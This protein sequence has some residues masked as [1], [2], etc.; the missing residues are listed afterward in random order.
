MYHQSS[1]PFC[2][3]DKKSKKIILKLIS[4][5]KLTSVKVLYG[6]PFMYHKT[7]KNDLHG[8]AVWEWDYAEM[9]LEKQYSGDKNVMWK[10]E[11]TPPKTK[12]L[13]YLFVIQDEKN[14]AFLYSENG[15]KEIKPGEIKI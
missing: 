14:N 15:I 7:A 3:Y 8:N 9:P 12:R 2:P 13:K 1:L 11:F 4:C 6:D 10:V 5:Q